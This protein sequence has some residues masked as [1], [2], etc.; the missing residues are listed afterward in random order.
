MNLQKAPTTRLHQ[1]LF[2]TACLLSASVVVHAA[3]AFAY[4]IPAAFVVIHAV[5][6]G[7]CWII[8]EQRRQWQHRVDRVVDLATEITAAH[9]R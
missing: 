3:L 5:A 9:R 4:Q 1:W 2:F 7:T 6:A 8:G